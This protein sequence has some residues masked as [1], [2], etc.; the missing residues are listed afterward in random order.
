M[1]KTVFEEFVEFPGNNDNRSMQ[2]NSR[3]FMYVN[4]KTL[5]GAF[6]PAGNVS[7]RQDVIYHS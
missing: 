4:V 2:G 3:K 6:P 1:K 5:T 7:S